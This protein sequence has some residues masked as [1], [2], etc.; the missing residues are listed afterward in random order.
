MDLLEG[1]A[2]VIYNLTSVCIDYCDY[3]KV[4]RDGI[5]SCVKSNLT[6]GGMAVPDSVKDLL[7]SMEHHI[8][9]Y[10]KYPDSQHSLRMIILLAQLLQYCLDFP[11]S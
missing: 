7:L 10:L 3:D 5:W 11:E 9:V 6:K 2:P 8:T 4:E 1:E